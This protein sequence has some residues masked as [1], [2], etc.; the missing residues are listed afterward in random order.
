[1]RISDSPDE[2]LV[3]YCLYCWKIHFSRCHP[4]FWGC[5]PYSHCWLTHPATCPECWN[6]QVDCDHLGCHP[7]VCNLPYKSRLQVILPFLLVQIAMYMLI[8]CAKYLRQQTR[9]MGAWLW[10]TVP[11]NSGHQIDVVRFDFGGE[12]GQFY[13]HCRRSCTMPGYFGIRGRY[14]AELKAD[15]CGFP[16]MAGTIGVHYTWDCFSLDM[17]ILGHW[18]A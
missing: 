11:K 16:W 18:A 14:F 6:I 2:N 15:S 3:I 12:M 8:S 9:Q 4:V 13:A 10:C 7:R 1:M 5:I 17:G